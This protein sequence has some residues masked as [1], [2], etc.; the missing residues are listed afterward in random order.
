MSGES[1]VQDVK[2]ATLLKKDIVV[3]LRNL[4]NL[5]EHLFLQ[6]TSTL[7]AASGSKQC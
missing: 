1:A 2:P 7:M 5:Y 6:N 3:L 4:R